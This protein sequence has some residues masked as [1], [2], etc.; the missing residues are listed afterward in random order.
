MFNSMLQGSII[1]VVLLTASACTTNKTIEVD[2][3][4]NGSRV[5]MQTGDTLVITLEGNITT[6]YQW[7]LL[8]NNDNILQLQGE[9]EY[10]Q[11]SA[12]KL[13]GAG[14][15]YHFTFKAAKA[16]NTSVAL[17]YYRSFEPADVAPIEI[18]GVVVVVK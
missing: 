13:M 7:E 4:S 10:V 12:G 15:V 6:G 18:F 14:G 3:E 2:A 1:L 16:G 17:K 9:P 8:P 11:K 5:E